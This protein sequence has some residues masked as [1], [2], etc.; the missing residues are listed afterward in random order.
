MAS[1][2]LR[3]VSV[4]LGDSAENKEEDIRLL[5]VFPLDLSQI[6]VWKEEERVPWYESQAEDLLQDPNLFAVSPE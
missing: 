4:D 2:F 6:L 3:E 1:A 5:N